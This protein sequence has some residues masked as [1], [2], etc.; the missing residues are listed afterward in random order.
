MKI[1]LSLSQVEFDLSEEE[2]QGSF[3]QALSILLVRNQHTEESLLLPMHEIAQRLDMTIEAFRLW[4]YRDEELRKLAYLSDGS[5]APP[6]KRI[7]KYFRLSEVR[8]IF[9]MRKK[10]KVED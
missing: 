4:L 2:T 8:P 10:A 7:K 3:G 9:A 5:P 6:S 1:R